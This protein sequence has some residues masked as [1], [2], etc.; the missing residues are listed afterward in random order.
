MLNTPR[1][2]RRPFVPADAAALFRLLGDPEA[3]RFSM[4]GAHLSVA[5]TDRWIE[6]KIQHQAK[7]GFA[8]G[9][10]LRRDDNDIIGKCGLEVLSDGGIEI[11]DRLRRDMW[12]Q[13]HATEAGQAWLNYA[14]STLGL[15][16]VAAMIEEA[17][18]RSVR[19][20]EKIGMQAGAPEIF[21]R[22]PV[23]EHFAQICH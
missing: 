10:V 6:H 14:F 7:H 3:M 4:G 19:V 20:A 12:R 23:I 13:G 17:N 21:H 9:A 15:S 18:R 16:R 11:G 2:T 22:N 8:I 5:A 1:L